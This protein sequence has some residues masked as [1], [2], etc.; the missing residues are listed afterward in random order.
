MFVFYVYSVTCIK[1]SKCDT[2]FILSVSVVF[3]TFAAIFAYSVNVLFSTFEASYMN[4]IGM[5]FFSP[6]TATVA[7]NVNIMFESVPHSGGRT[8]L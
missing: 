5:C 7:L 2:S 1:L 4:L 3:S 6:F 8:P